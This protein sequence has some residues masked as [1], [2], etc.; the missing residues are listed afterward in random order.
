MLAVTLAEAVVFSE[1]RENAAII[2]IVI[3]AKAIEKI[4]FFIN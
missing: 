3:A 4:P 2:A 1:R